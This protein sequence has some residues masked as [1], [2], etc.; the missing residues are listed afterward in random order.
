MRKLNYI[1]FRKLDVFEALKYKNTRHTHT[2]LFITYYASHSYLH[3][4]QFDMGLLPCLKRIS[5]L[6]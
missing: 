5:A 6:I 1:L 2:Q 3:Y 4:M